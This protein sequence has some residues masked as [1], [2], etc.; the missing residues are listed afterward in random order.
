MMVG[1]LSLLTRLAMCYNATII[2]LM[3]LSLLLTLTWSP[4]SKL[5][6]KKLIEFLQELKIWTR[7]EKIPQNIQSLIFQR[8]QVKGVAKKKG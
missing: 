6:E 1:E 3:A 8:F 5:V 4:L 2:I 7:A